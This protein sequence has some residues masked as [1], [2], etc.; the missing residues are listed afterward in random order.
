MKYVWFLKTYLLHVW[1]EHYQPFPLG[2]VKLQILNA[3]LPAVADT[4]TLGTCLPNT[5]G[6]QQ[7]S[8]ESSHPPC[9]SSSA[10]RSMLHRGCFYSL[11]NFNKT[12]WKLTQ[13]TV[14]MCPN[15]PVL[16]YSPCQ[17]RDLAICTALRARQLSKAPSSGFLPA[18]STN[19]LSAEAAIF[20]HLEII[21]LHLK[22]DESHIWPKHFPNLFLNFSAAV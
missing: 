16:L 18:C 2:N 1:G 21:Y 22:N 7:W 19:I 8:K 14:A 5:K 10:F 4:C 3:V 12:I 6:S 20:L 13:M 9:C 11:K 17:S 15:H